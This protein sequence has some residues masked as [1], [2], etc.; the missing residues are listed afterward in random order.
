MVRPRAAAADNISAADFPPDKV[1]RQGEQALAYGGVCATWTAVGVAL[2][3]APRGVVE[4]AWAA[5]PNA[6]VSSFARL[7]GCTFLLVG[8]VAHCLQAAAE[9]GRLKS[10]TYLRLNL[11]LMWWGAGLAGTL[12]VQAA[13]A[14]PAAQWGLTAL[15]AATALL[16]AGVYQRSSPR[17]LDPV[18]LVEQFL[19]S[20]KQLSVYSQAKSPLLPAY[21]YG[22][23][24]RAAFL[25]GISL[26]M[27]TARLAQ[28]SML[29][30][31]LGVLGHG[32]LHSWAVGLLLLSTVLFT[33]KDA[34]IRGRL[35][36]STF[37]ALNLGTAAVSTVTVATMLLAVIYGTVNMR[38]ATW[39]KTVSWMLLS[40]VALYEFFNAKK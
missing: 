12:W 24:S 19:E 16:G 26:L 25:L 17:G 27:G 15:A 35:G 39:V 18:Y 10:E 9:H 31:P 5:T 29:N 3:L 38:L 1:E 36:A 11:G 30:M 2:V 40:V 22:I 33:L 7:L 32:I 4:L 6:V 28:G 20:A 34:A 13:R 23:M 37:R 21:T 14:L 8:V